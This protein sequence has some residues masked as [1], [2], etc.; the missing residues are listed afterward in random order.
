MRKNREGKGGQDN[1]RTRL[2]GLSSERGNRFC[3]CSSRIR[4]CGWK[5][6]GG[7]FSALYKEEHLS[8]TGHW[9]TLNSS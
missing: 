6:L 8:T 3:V 9:G 2:E 1:G 4:T 5:L 7:S